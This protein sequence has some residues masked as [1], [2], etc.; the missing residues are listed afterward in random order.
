[1]KKIRLSGRH[2]DKYALVDDDFGFFDQH[3]WRLS[4]YGY[5]VANIK[6]SLGV[7]KTTQL[8]RLI[9]NAPKNKDVDHKNHNLLDNRKG[10][11]RLCTKSENLANQLPQ[12]GKTSQY[13]GVSWRKERNNWRVRVRIKDK[14]FSIGSFDNE[15]EAATAYN[16]KAEEIFGEF[17]CINNL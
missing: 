15:V 10:N 6:H 8:S 13:K 3:R 16:L 14:D 12:K 9:M 1:M 11:L 7:R 17:A 2:N 4:A 5:V